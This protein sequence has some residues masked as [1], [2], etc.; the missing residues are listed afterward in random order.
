M[1]YDLV[2]TEPRLWDLYAMWSRNRGEE[3]TIANFISWY[4]ERYSE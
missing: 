3:P 2:A 1:Q 4:E